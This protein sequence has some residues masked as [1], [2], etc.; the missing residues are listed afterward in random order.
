M[1]PTLGQPAWSS[2]TGGNKLRGL[3]VL[4]AIVAG[5]VFGVAIALAASDGGEESRPQISG[6]FDEKTA[7]LTAEIAA[8]N[9]PSDRL[10][11]VKADL[12]T[13]KEGS[14]IDDPRPWDSRGSL[15][16]ERAYVGPDADGNVSH[17]LEVPVLINGPY[18]HIVV[19]ATTDKDDELCTELPAPRT[20]AEKTACM[21]IPLP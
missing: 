4:V 11:I 19:E 7:T 14:G 3:F 20:P 16:L 18:T 1:A 10:L 17:D 6:S 15:P 8:S 5:L 13:V 9:L 2:S 12:Q 21:V